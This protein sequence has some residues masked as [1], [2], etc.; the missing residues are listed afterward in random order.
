MP[1]TDS[2]S[3]F[4]PLFINGTWRLPTCLSFILMQ[5]H[6][7]FDIYPQTMS[8]TIDRSRSTVSQPQ[9]ITVLPSSWPADH[10]KVQSPDLVWFPLPGQGGYFTTSCLRFTLE[11]KESAGDR[12]EKCLNTAGGKH[13][14]LFLDW[15]HPAIVGALP[16]SG[17]EVRR[18]R[19]QLHFCTEQ[20]APA[21]WCWWRIMSAKEEN[22]PLTSVSLEAPYTVYTVKN[23]RQDTTMCEFQQLFGWPIRV[24]KIQIHM[25]EI[26]IR[27]TWRSVKLHFYTK[28]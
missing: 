12:E 23:S 27:V 21:D 15:S 3:G 1:W 13:G 26:E 19:N 8:N 9:Y 17:T 25:K 2:H 22:A 5:G 6:L 4:S 10:K 24:L 18:G 11:A 28:K 7:V 20:S 16:K 14:S